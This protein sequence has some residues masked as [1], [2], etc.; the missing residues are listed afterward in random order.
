VAAGTRVAPAE[1]AGATCLLDQRPDTPAHTEVQR[2]D[3]AA[4]GRERGH[5]D[6][7]ALVLGAEQSVRRD[8]AADGGADPGV[9]REVAEA[10]EALDLFRGQGHAAAWKN[11]RDEK[12]GE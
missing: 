12:K 2:G 6:A 10:G 9:G 1:R 4:L 7:P 3:T 8:R 5:R 11:S